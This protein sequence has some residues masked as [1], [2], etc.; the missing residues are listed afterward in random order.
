MSRKSQ[1]APQATRAPAQPSSVAPRSSVPRAATA[2]RTS[3]QADY[4][5]N[6]ATDLAPIAPSAEKAGVLTASHLG[7]NAPDIVASAVDVE[8]SEDSPVVRKYRVEAEKNIS[9]NGIRSILRAGKE[10]DE[11]NYD[12]NLLKKQGVKLTDITA[13][14]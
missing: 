14:G 13:E 12:I 6:I 7:S 10:I 4:A 5:G 1:V 8:A 2:R 3:E 11:N 9:H